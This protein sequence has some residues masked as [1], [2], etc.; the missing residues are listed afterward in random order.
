MD[1]TRG[2]KGLKKQG[3][4]HTGKSSGMGQN[5]QCQP[6]YTWDGNKCAI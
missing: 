5:M 3:P 6:G 2:K 1:I 4:S